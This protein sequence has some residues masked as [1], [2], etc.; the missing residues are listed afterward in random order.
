MGAKGYQKAITKLRASN[1]ATRGLLKEARV[2][3]FSATTDLIGGIYGNLGTGVAGVG[4]QM[5]LQNARQLR[6]L[7]AVADRTVQGNSRDVRGGVR[8]AQNL[9]GGAVTGLAAPEFARAAG[10]SKAAKIALAG[11]ARAGVTT[12]Q[13]ANTVLG[14]MQAGVAEAQAGAVAQTADALKYRAKNDAQII[15]AQQNMI[16][17]SKLD[18]QNWKRQ[19]DYLK[20]QEQDPSGQ[21]VGVSQVTDL[22]TSGAVKMRQY[23][24]DHPDATV[25]ELVG[26]VTAGDT[27]LQNNPNV[28][29]VL[30]ELARQVKQSVGSDGTTSDG[31]SRADE[32]TDIYNSV[33]L[34]YPNYK[35][36]KQL[37]E[38]IKAGLDAGWSAAQVAAVAAQAADTT[39]AGV[40]NPL[41]T[42]YQVGPGRGLYFN[43]P[44]PTT[45]T[46]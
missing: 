46:P 28:S 8:T 44:D 45:T 37:R 22:A 24:V 32:A 14:I 34:L 10:H 18:F 25:D 1:I 16:L 35:N 26:L 2:G 43:P 27:A 6:A 21:A 4:S 39:P 38:T 30:S 41:G 17:Q 13:G 9:F 20:K 19:Q 33:L 40:G 3:G 31:Y 29:G 36:V 12:A 42:G 5:T 15:A 23:L 11:A 7:A